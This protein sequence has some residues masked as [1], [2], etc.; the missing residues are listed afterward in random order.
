MIRTVSKR[1]LIR[2]KIGI[3]LFNKTAAKDNVEVN[4]KDPDWDEGLP[5]VNIYYIDEDI[6]ETCQQP[7]EYNRWTNFAIEVNAKDDSEMDADDY[8]DQIDQ[9]IRNILFKDITLGGLA[10]NIE[11]DHPV[12]IFDN[13]GK[14][15]YGAMGCTWR[16]LHNDVVLEDIGDKDSM[17]LADFKVMKT[18]WNTNKENL[19]PVGNMIL[20][21]EDE[22]NL[23][24]DE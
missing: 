10:Q 4:S 15:R 22:L 21:A 20:E 24:Q 9:E 17:G 1:K 18:R 6:D 23:P 19:D 3:L 12:W 5:A 11:P 2:D 8:L 13:T 7:R 14:G 16:I